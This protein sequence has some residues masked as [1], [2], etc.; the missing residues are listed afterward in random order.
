MLQELVHTR[1]PIFQ[2][3]QASGRGGIADVQVTHARENRWSKDN[4]T[5]R[6]CT[7]C[8]SLQLRC[9]CETKSQHKLRAAETTK[10]ISN[11][12]R[13]VSTSA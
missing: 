8:H 1:L 4:L 11:P 6:D 12:P 9:R 2:L 13:N 5:A 10:T 3:L 7:V